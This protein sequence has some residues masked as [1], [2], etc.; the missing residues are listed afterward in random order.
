MVHSQEAFRDG[1]F[2]RV[3]SLS[4]ALP[5]PSGREHSRRHGAARESDDCRP[6][7]WKIHGPRCP[8]SR[9]ATFGASAY[10]P[11]GGFLRMVIMWRSEE[12]R[13]GKD[14]KSQRS[15]S[16]HKRNDAL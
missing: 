15:T 7:V 11:C 14:C 5:P 16:Q 9:A 8:L 12:R 4:A 2:V 6:V 10:Q 3:A 13:V 1:G